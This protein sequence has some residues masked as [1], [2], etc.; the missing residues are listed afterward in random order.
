MP[1]FENKT[2]IFASVLIILPIII[3]LFGMK[4]PVREIFGPLPIILRIK[5]KIVRKKRLHSLLLILLRMLLILV[6][7]LAFS[8]MYLT[9]SVK[10]KESTSYCLMIIDNSP[11]AGVQVDGKTILVSLFHLIDKYV[12]ENRGNCNR[13]TIYALSDKIHF[14]TDYDGIKGGELKKRILVGDRPVNMKNDLNEALGIVSNIKFGKKVL[15]SD[16]YSHFVINP[17]EAAEFFNE[18]DIEVRGLNLP[19]VANVFINQVRYENAQ[20]G[21]IRV[22][23]DVENGGESPFYG[24]LKIYRDEVLFER[25]ELNLAGGE[26]REVTFDISEKNGSVK[27]SLYSFRLEGDNFDYDN[28]EYSYYAEK[29]RGNILLVNGEPSSEESRSEI[30]YLRNAIGSYFSN[31]LK[32]YSVLEDMLPETPELYDIIVLANVSKIDLNN[33]AIL[34]RYVSEG[35]RLL[36]TL[37]SRVSINDYNGMQFMPALIEGLSEADKEE[38]LTIEDNIFFDPISEQTWGFE[39]VRFIKLFDLKALADSKVILSTNKNRPVLVMRD[40]GKGKIILYGSSIDMDMNDFPIRKSYVPFIALLFNRMLQGSLEKRVIYSHPAE[41]ISIRLYQC[42]DQKVSIIGK[43]IYNQQGVCITDTSGNK[44]IRLNAPEEPGFYSL[45]LDNT[46]V[47]LIVNT[48]KSESILKRID[49]GSIKKERTQG[50]SEALSIGKLKNGNLSLVEF[51]M[52]ISALVLLSEMFV[53]N[54]R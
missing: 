34:S 4:R 8:G 22:F 41:K 35:G 38:S 53:M 31:T 47:L 33:S 19:S 6:V 52:V 36:I 37:G 10:E 28:T 14:E 49:P 21:N 15:F 23:T 3:H 40:Y 26:K 30:F 1:G 50:I 27:E 51:L 9:S 13:Y 2:L 24:S 5:R 20:E 17:E 11:S 18:W 54:R 32:I 7:V 48:D 42:K 43:K 39:R 29:D 45:S 44:Y 12:E 46:N 16:L 25:A